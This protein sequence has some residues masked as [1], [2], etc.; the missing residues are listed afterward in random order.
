MAYHNVACT[1]HFLLLTD[2]SLWV[3]TWLVSG[4]W[5]GLNLL[6]IP[7]FWIQKRQKLKVNETRSKKCKTEVQDLN[8]IP[9]CEETGILLQQNETPS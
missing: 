8:V 1:A 4:L 2:I 9:Q 6:Q 7:T 3:N 5:P